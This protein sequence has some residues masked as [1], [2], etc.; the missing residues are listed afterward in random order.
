MKRIALVLITLAFAAA[1]ATADFT[2]HTA[3]VLTGN[4]GWSSVGL[5]FNV[6]SQIKVLE[7]GI[8]DSAQDGIK[9]LVTGAPVTLST[10]IFDSAKNVLAQMD[11][12]TNDT[13]TLV[14]AYRW[15]SLATPLTLAPGQYA[16]VG[17]GFH[18]GT[19]NEY[20]ANFT[21]TGWPT[22]DDGGGLISF[23]DSVWGDSPGVDMPP[24]YPTRSGATTVHGVHDFFDG[25]NMTYVPV[26]GAAMLGILGL[27]A[28]AAR[29]RKR[30]V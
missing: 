19:N 2:M 26:P 9:P 16:I 10:L 29:L 7:L 12:S 3:N 27:G 24:I 11:F 15:K 6:N 14:G 4:Q 30:R 18:L 21:H 20:N 23:V 8:Y 13:G 22:F 1:P 5:T 17:Y 28:A 25:P